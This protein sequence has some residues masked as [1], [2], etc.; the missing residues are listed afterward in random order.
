M[1]YL[2]YLLHKHHLLKNMSWLGAELV[3][4]LVHLSMLTP[5]DVVQSSQGTTRKVFILGYSCAQRPP[6]SGRLLIT[7]LRPNNQRGHPRKSDSAFYQ[8]GP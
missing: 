2:P 1:Y 4:L 8:E 3:R 5:Q 7:E 6:A